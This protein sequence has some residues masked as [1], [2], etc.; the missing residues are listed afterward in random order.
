MDRIR[1]GAL[2]LLLAACGGRDDSAAPCADAELGAGEHLEDF[3][4]L[5]TYVHVPDVDGCAPL[6]VYLHGTSG[7]GTWDGSTWVPP[8]RMSLVTDA[9][10]LG[11]VLA[12]PGVSAGADTHEWQLD[13][14]GAAQID[15]A[16]VGAGERAPIDPAKRF[17][18]G[19]SKGGE[20]ASW[21]G[22]RFPTI[23]RGIA[24][25]SGGYARGYPDEEPDPKLPYYIA[26]DPRDPDV[27][28]AEAA[29]LEADLDAHGHASVLE[30]WELGEDG[31]GWNP[32]LM[33]PVL[34]YLL[35]PS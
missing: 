11:F 17:V 10:A 7:A 13:E 3:D 21:Y 20:T 29:A 34:A 5:S 8:D 35:D 14:S 31:H 2:P 16:L 23:A 19:V 22:L 1:G 12:V 33:A 32:D 25:V 6:V 18:L 15:A 30:D 27:P 9:N 24:T 26:H 28:Y 4:G